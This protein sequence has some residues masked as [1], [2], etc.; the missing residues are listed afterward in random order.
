M[1]EFNQEVKKWIQNAKICRKCLTMMDIVSAGILPGKQ[2]NYP[3][4][5]LESETYTKYRCPKCCLSYRE[6]IKHIWNN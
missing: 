4:N 5:P 6:E 1:E 3:D 2:G